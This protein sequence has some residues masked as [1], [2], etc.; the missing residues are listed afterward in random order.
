M[1]WQGEAGKRYSAATVSMGKA[2]RSQGSNVLAGAQ[3]GR[4][5]ELFIIAVQYRSGVSKHAVLLPHQRG[6]GGGMAP[7]CACCQLRLLPADC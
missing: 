3:R 4:V 7:G 5:R 2:G 6:G 1:Q